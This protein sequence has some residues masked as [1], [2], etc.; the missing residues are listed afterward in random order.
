[1]VDNS[2]PLNISTGNPYLVPSYQHRV[3]TNLTS[4]NPTKFMNFFGFV[5]A[6]YTK[7]PIIS[8]QTVSPS[9]VR[10][11]K[12][13][14]VADNVNL[15]ANISLGVPIRKLK[16]RFNI[17][18]TGVYSRGTNVLNDQSSYIWQQTYGGT[19]RYN[20]SIGEIFSLDLS[21]NLSHQETTYEFNTANNQ[22]YFNKTYSA[23]T[24]VTFLKRNQFNTNFDYYIYN[25]QTTSYNQTI[26]LWN[27]SVSRFVMKN[28][29]GEVKLG[30]NNLLDQ[31][32]SVAQSATSNY[33]QQQVT[34]NL[35]R[36]IM[37]SFTYSLNKQLNPNAGMRN[38]G[39]GGG[40][41]IMRQQN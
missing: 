13:V 7:N 37:L 8:S 11:T 30:V 25:S 20:L 35:G 32:I 10:V 22:V 41:R 24:Y 23:E 5:T 14:N 3:S 36:Y 1:M 26:P 12:P 6:T 9:L 21:A 33:L 15:T 19:V 27:M 18:P 4:F 2:D 38:G 29:V 16:S 39:G 28:N 17:G 40:M 31:S 34:N